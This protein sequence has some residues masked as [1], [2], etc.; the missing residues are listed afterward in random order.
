[1]H[2]DIFGKQMAIGKNYFGVWMVAMNSKSYM[3][4]CEGDV[5]DCATLACEENNS[6]IKAGFNIV[7]CK[8]CGRKLCIFAEPKRE[9]KQ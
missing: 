9:T 2:K 3:I 4:K 8:K 6:T 1:M 7:A 5:L